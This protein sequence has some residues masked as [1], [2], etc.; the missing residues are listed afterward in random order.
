[1]I[2]TYAQETLTASK[3]FY[4]SLKKGDWL[5]LIIAVII[6]SA[7]V[8]VVKQLGETI[9][10]SMLRKAA[11]SMGAD[12]VIQS[13]RPIDT[14]W[15]QKAKQLGLKTSQEIS[16][17]TMALTANPKSSEQQFQ[18]VQL[19]GISSS[20][21]LRGSYNPNQLL[22]FSDLGSDTIWV[23]PK[24]VSLMKLTA[25]SQLTLGNKKFKLAGSIESPQLINP[26]A[27]F[28]PKIW[29]DIHQLKSLKLIGPGSRV[30][31]QLSVAGKSQLIKAFSQLVEKNKLGHWQFI[32]AQAPSEDLGNSLD[33]AWL[34]LDLS[35]LSAVL[36]AG[37][38]I[39]I[40]SR[41]YLTR[42]QNSMALMRA[43]GAGNAKMTRLFALQLTWI[44]LFSSLIG[45]A[46]GY[47]ITL[48][49]TPYLSDYFTPLIIAS[50]FSAMLIGFFS[51]LLV[52]W[53][54]A[55]QAFQTALKTSPLQ[56]LK[57]VPRQTSYLHWFV[58]FSLL[59]VL[60][61][62]ML[63]IDSL[64][65][66][67]LGIVIISLTLFL[68]SVLLLKMLF[69][70][71]NH[72]RGWFKI[73]LSN[74]T[75]EPGLVKIQMVSVGMV[76]FV[77]ILMTFVRQ[78]LL[79]NWQATLPGNTPNTFVMN[80]QPDQKPAV[81]KILGN[82]DNITNVPVVRGRLIKINNQA[83]TIEQQTEEKARR[84]LQREA[85][86]AV[87][88]EIPQHNQITEASSAPLRFPKVSVEQGIAELFNI[89][90]GD[91]LD[92]NIAGQALRY[93]VS[94]I[95]K[96][97]WQSFQLNFF[98][99]IE[100]VTS[101]NLPISYL[102]NFYLKEAQS[103]ADSNSAANLSRQLSL[104]TPGVLLIDVKKILLQIQEI[105][106]Q[107]SW[108]VS[109]LYLFTLLASI[110]VLFTATLASQQSRIQ[111]WLLLRT[112]G[113]QNKEIIKIGLT[114]FLFLGGLAGILAAS[115]AQIA[116][117]LI[118]HYLLKT[119]PSLTPSL[120]LMSILIGSSLFL[121]IGLITQWSYLQKSPQQLKLYLNSI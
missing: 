97:S 57:S 75:K 85:N 45:V 51:G 96:V 73:A 110:G 78:D 54:F 118:S 60:I 16:I 69:L 15:Q 10:Q 65:W 24:L 23:E 8:T 1:M 91:I 27:N 38:S 94:S 101:I 43:F 108:A 35:A 120:W 17:V 115:F 7:T 42:W 104:Q 37:M 70:L 9:Q 11:D 87:I 26:M 50:P 113:A 80:I 20:Q 89:K 34:F 48:F 14:Q 28:A 59:L 61:S 46:L 19:Q 67:L 106:A 114:E 100:P 93:Q 2:K 76:L 56:I 109:A 79:Q 13:S 41:F 62:L 3:W 111:S 5:W 88:S 117:L 49:I 86:I 71:Q 39:L 55:W 98:F 36:V 68:A 31:Y 53:T 112:L 66:I 105:M 72:S 92:F 25:D 47:L 12:F 6:A 64:L 58:S 32:S 99:I 18:L 103:N 116:S 30:S 77:L 74:L 107:A 119:D 90:L 33:T 52:L 102:S 44:A 4:R 83:I 29:I 22:P 84:L 81:D 40:A 95:R 82:I 121:L 63:E 21:P